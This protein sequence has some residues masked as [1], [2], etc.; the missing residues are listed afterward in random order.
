[1]FRSIIL[2]LMMVVSL[3]A[4]GLVP[5]DLAAYNF[6]STSADDVCDG[7]IIVLGSYDESGRFYF[8]SSKKS[9]ITKTKKLAGVPSKDIEDALPDDLQ[10]VARSDGQ[11]FKLLTKDLQNGIRSFT[12]NY[13]EINRTDG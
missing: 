11:G 3:A 7:D 2:T 10:W 12:G 4:S 13:E 1:M 6:V 5:P 9:S 8:M